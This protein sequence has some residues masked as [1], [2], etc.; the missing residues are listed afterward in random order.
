[1]LLHPRRLQC[2]QRIE[3]FLG[4]F[5]PD[6]NRI[7]RIIKWRIEFTGVSLLVITLVRVHLHR[8]PLLNSKY[9]RCNFGLILACMM[10]NIFL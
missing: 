6:F 7:A 2:A 3:P 10:L 4:S 1:M 5:F 8:N 9:I